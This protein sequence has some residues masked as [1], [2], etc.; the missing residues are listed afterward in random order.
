MTSCIRVLAF[1]A[2]ASGLSAAEP[3]LTVTGPDRTLSFS[4]ADFAALP[5][6]EISAFDPHGKAD[7][8]YSGVAMGEILARAGAPMGDKLRGRAA[9]QLVVIAHSR[10]GY[11]IVFALAEFDPAFS[12]RPVLLADAEDGKPL[13]DTAGPLRMVLPGDKKAARWARMVDSIEIRPA[14]A[15]APAAKP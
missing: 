9:L 7:H 4:A 10:D 1:L 5:H 12:D 3:V 6:T 2:L 8:K 11:A 15:A 13:P 14:L